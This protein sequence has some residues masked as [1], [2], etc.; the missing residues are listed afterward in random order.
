MLPLC[1][2]LQIRQFRLS[3]FLTVLATRLGPSPQ[4]STPCKQTFPCCTAHL[5]WLVLGA[6]EISL[7]CTRDTTGNTSSTRVTS[8]FTVLKDIFCTL[9]G[10]LYLLSG[11]DSI[12]QS[13]LEGITL[14]ILLEVMIPLSLSVLLYIPIRF[15]ARGKYFKIFTRSKCFFFISM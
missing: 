15:L 1:S 6:W 8:S 10:V 12:H 5:V 11:N 14:S 3:I 7:C 9:H 13:I 2:L 4:S